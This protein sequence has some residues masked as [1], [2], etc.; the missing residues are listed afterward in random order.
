MQKAEFSVTLLH[1]RYWLTWLGF[2]LWWLVAQLPY[3]WQ[4][5]LGRGLGRVLYHLAKRRRRIA[6]RNIALCFPEL[7]AR[8]QQALVRTNIESTAIAV[9]ESGMAWFWPPARLKKLF[10]VEGLEHLQAAEAAQQGVLLLAMHFTNL[11]IGG[12]LLRQVHKIDAMYRPHNNAVYDYLQRRGRERIPGSRLYPRED[13]RQIVKDLRAGRAIWYAPDQDYGQRSGVFA[14][15]F[16]VP[17]A[18]VTATAQ[19]A[20]LGK[21]QVVPFVQTRQ[22]RGGYVVKIYPPLQG[23][24]TG[25]DLAD[26]TRI[27]ALVEARVRENPSQYMW[28]HRRFKTRPEGEPSVYD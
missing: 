13:L 2:G 28:V 22:P 5:S 9:F 15:F 25:D 18:T 3:Q 8:E 14:P 4:L 16:G 1:P 23:F 10:R 27:N 20:R 19:L 24:P 12:M 11:D 26:A 21:A 7:S 6:E 17:A